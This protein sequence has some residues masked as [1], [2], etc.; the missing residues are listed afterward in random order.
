MQTCTPLVHSLFE[1]VTFKHVSQLNSVK[2]ECQ[3][4]HPK[5]Y[6]IQAST[7]HCLTSKPPCRK[8]VV[9]GTV[10]ESQNLTLD[11]IRDNLIRQEDTIIFSLIERA[12]FRLNP[13]TYDSRSNPVPGFEGSLLDYLLKETEHLHAKVGSRYMFYLGLSL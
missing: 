13:A 8:T 9:L 10:D 1:V 7:C 4:E 11:K 5:S 12:Q 3:H 6:H 2:P